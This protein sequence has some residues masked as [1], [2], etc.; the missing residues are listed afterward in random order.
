MKDAH[1]DRHDND[2][3]SHKPFISYGP[4][5]RIFRIVWAVPGYQIGILRR[6]RRRLG[7]KFD[8]RILWFIAPVLLDLMFY[9]FRF[10]VSWRGDLFGII[11]FIPRC[12]R[13]FVRLP[14]T[15]VAD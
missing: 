12:V 5:L 14:A 13:N 1:V 8:W 4:V 6:V 11:R 7:R 10:F 3:D 2:Y 15:A 9:P